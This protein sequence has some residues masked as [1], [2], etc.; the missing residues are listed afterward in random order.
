MNRARSDRKRSRL[1]SGRKR[2]WRRSIKPASYTFPRD[3]ADY[4]EGPLI[5]KSGHRLTADVPS[6]AALTT[7][8]WG[9]VQWTVE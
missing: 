5:L 3:R 7:H 2:Y 4:I 9:I 6:E 8:L 1:K